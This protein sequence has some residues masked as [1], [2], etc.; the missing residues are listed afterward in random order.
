MQTLQ[1]AIARDCV[2]TGCCPPCS[3]YAITSV[4]EVCGQAHAPNATWLPRARLWYVLHVAGG[5]QQCRRKLGPKP[6]ASM[7]RDTFSGSK[8][9]D[10]GHS[11]RDAKTAEHKGLRLDGLLPALFRVCLHLSCRGMWEADFAN[12]CGIA[13]VPSVARGVCTKCYGGCASSLISMP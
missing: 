2:P 1:R 5:V 8:Y 4:V 7:P 6:T 10:T 12:K 9:Y 3:G 13:T 11:I